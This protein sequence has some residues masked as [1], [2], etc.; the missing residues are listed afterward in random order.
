VLVGG[1]LDESLALNG[2]EAVDD[3]F[4]GGNLASELDLSD[5]GGVAVLVDVLLR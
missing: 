1:S 3:G 2:V 4:V 5:E